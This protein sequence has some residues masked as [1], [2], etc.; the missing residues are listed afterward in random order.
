MFLELRKLHSNGAIRGYIIKIL[1]GNMGDYLLL[2]DGSSLPAVD[3]VLWQLA[4]RDFVCEKAGGKR[5]MV[6]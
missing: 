4:K 2:I 5:G 3:A 1:G 6:S